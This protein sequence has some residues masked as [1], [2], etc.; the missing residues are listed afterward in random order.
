MP[1]AGPGPAATTRRILLDGAVT[2]VTEDGGLLR[3]PDGRTVEAGQAVRLPPCQPGKVLCVHLNYRSRLTEVRAAAPATPTYFH[4]PVSALN[5]HGGAVVRPAGCQ[6][7]NYEG[8]VAIV[9]GAAA[10][11]ARDPADAARC[12][13]TLGTAVSG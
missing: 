3:A 6:W 9:I 2:E 5:A 13:V 1:A 4:K 12:R 7:L 10:I 11:I 8:E